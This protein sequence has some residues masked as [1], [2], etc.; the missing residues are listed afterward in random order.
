MKKIAFLACT[1]LFAS[2]TIAQTNVQVLTARSITWGGLDFSKAK[3]IGSEGFSDPDDIT[4]NYFDKWNKLIVN[5]ASKYNFGEAYKK[6]KVVNDLSVAT[7]QN[8]TVDAS[9]LVTEEDYSF[10]SGE[11]EEIVSKYKGIGEGDGTGLIYVIES[12]NKTEEASSIYLVFFDLATGEILHSKK[13]TEAPGGFGLRNYWA[14][15]I[16]RTIKVSEK[17]YKKALKSMRK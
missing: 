8:A 4:D 7:E 17:D 5:E 10:S 12:F 14:G 1:L 3:M 11:L 2:Q 6:D 15:A 13:Y 9:E 16:G